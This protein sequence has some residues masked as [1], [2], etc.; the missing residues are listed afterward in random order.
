MALT[1]ELIRHG[2]TILQEPCPR[3]GAVQIKFHGKVYCTNEDDLESLLNPVSQS[4]AP[5]TVQGKLEEKRPEPATSETTNSVRKLLEEKL[6]I[7]SKQ[8]DSTT[9]ID[10]QA[11]ILELM[12]KYL[13]TL[14]KV[15]RTSSSV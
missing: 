1:A 13:E 2:A 4:G 11:K 8:L 15:K 3:C 6:N 12:S 5:P 7:L 9:D 14:E 10:E